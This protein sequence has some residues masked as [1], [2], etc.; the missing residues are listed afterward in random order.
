MRR[1]HPAER[2]VGEVARGR[3]GFKT[4]LEKARVCGQKKK[5][6]RRRGRVT[7]RRQEENQPG[8]EPPARRPERREGRWVSRWRSS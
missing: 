8:L 2:G 4:E 6:W 3:S 7:E 1:P 5:L